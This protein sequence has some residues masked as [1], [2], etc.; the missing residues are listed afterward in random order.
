MFG[1]WPLVENRVRSNSTKRQTTTFRYVL[2]V[3]LAVQ[4]ALGK[5]SLSVNCPHNHHNRALGIVN[6][7]FARMITFGDVDGDPACN[8]GPS[9]EARRPRG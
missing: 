9:G 1:Q 4:D 3:G 2:L 5:P 8:A 6:R 7:K